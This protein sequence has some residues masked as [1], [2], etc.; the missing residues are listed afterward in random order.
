[1]LDFSASNIAEMSV[2]EFHA[3]R[4]GMFFRMVLHQLGEN[5]LLINYSEL[6]T[7]TGLL[8]LLDFLKINVSSDELL[9]MLDKLKIYSKDYFERKIHS[10]DSLSKQKV[11][12]S[13]VRYLV[14]KWTMEPYL[15][16]EKARCSQSA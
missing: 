5:I 14:D 2:E 15:E 7:Q 11:A 12:S 3:R 9:I 16:L 6:I 4:L 1:M 10:N 13:K 8:R